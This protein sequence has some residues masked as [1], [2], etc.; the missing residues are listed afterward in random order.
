[1]KELEEGPQSSSSL[2]KEFSKETKIVKQIQGLL[3]AKYIRHV[4][5]PAE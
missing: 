2:R 3:E 5:K 4:G 1:M